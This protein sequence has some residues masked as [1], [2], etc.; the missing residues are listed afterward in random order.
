MHAMKITDGPVFIADDGQKHYEPIKESMTYGVAISCVEVEKPMA[1]HSHPP[2][3]QIYY[4]RSGRGIVTVDGEEME[5]E[6]D[7]VI[8][9][10]SGA[11]H[12]MRPLDGDEPL[13]YIYV[14][15]FL[16]QPSS[17]GYESEG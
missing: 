11:E 13:T 15:H 5:V 8:F 10:P 1:I 4:V 9:I 14:T 6:K 16:D 3:E 17:H 7:M 2:M 12:G